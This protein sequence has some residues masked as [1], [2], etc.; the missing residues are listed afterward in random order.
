[1]PENYSY[2]SFSKTGLAPVRDI[3][4]EQCEGYA[5]TQGELQIS[6][7]YGGEMEGATAYSFIDDRGLI[8]GYDKYAVIDAEG[9]E[10]LSP[11]LCSYMNIW[12]E[13]NVIAVYD[14]E[15]DVPI[16]YA[17]YSG[18]WIVEP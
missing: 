2:G 4:T 5:N 8:G 11:F 14:D 15:M 7:N 17:D 1:M 10:I 3:E 16:G 6:L 12:Q 9:N 13:D 18:D